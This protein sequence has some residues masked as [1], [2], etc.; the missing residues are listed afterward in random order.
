M[1]HYSYTQISNYLQCPLKYKYRYVDGWR[2]KDDKANLIF[3]RVF[4]KAVEAHFLGV[5]A[6]EFFTFQWSSFKTAPLEYGNGDSWERMLEQGQ[7]LLR[8]FRADQRIQ[9]EDARRDL[10]VKLCRPLMGSARDFLGYIDAL[11]WV[12]GTHC[13]IEWKTSTLSYPEST[14]RI[15]ELDPQ[16]ICY[17]WMTQKQDVCL[18]NFVRK[19]QPEIQ[20][21]HARIRKRQWKAFERILGTLVSDIKARTFYPRSGIRYP[22]NQCL[23]CSYLGLCLHQK[24][25]VQENLT[26]IEER[27]V[28]G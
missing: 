21:L 13:V 6:V 5:E 28:D 7:D 17:S 4:Q 2:E 8:R 14:P 23:N 15:L 16:L 27:P 18:V 24:R 19:K 22:N 12:D 11:G 20:Y 3:G 10:Q 1:D 9:I 25:L 26:R